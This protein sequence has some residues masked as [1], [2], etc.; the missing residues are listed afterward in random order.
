MENCKKALVV[1]ADDFGLNAQ[2]NHGIEWAYRQGILRSASIMPNGSAF[3]DAVRIAA[4]APELGVGIHLSLL[5]EQCAARLSEVRGLADAH[6]RL[7]KQYERFLFLWLCRRFNRRQIRAEVRAQISRVLGA[8]IQPTHLD[9]HQHLHLFPP[10]LSIVLEEAKKAGIDV[11]RLPVDCSP[12]SGIKGKILGWLSCFAQPKLRFLGIRSAD[13]FWGLAHSGCMNETNLISILMR[14]KRGVNEVMCHPGFS[15]PAV[16]ARYP[17]NYR[18]DEETAALTS[19]SIRAC[20]ENQ[21]IRLANFS[22]A[23]N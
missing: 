15:G 23:W 3:D 8:G 21:N 2:I 4:G 20:I 6:S 10:V 14:L 11:I 18:W 16:R 12:G 5:D 7:P 19:G 17:W 1:N 9:S 13:H 22:N